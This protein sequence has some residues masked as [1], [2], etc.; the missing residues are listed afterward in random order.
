MTYL[1]QFIPEEIKNRVG[2][3]T[4]QELVTEIEL[5]KNYYWI[6]E[7]KKKYAI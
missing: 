4:I 6:N 3:I 1:D 7:F 2:S 5:N